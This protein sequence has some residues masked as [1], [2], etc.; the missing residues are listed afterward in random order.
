MSRFFCGDDEFY[1][2][3]S[4][5]R[6]IAWRHGL[7]FPVSREN[8]VQVVKGDLEE[9][10]LSLPMI[11]AETEI[12]VLDRENRVETFVWMADVAVGRRRWRSG[13]RCKL[14]RK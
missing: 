11:V 1:A 8:G 14:Q 7:V 5:L 13:C 12:G 9:S 6:H 3:G 4:T 2:F 10:M